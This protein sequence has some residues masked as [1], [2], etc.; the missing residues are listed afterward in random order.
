MTKATG[1][2]KTRMKATNTGENGVWLMKMLCARNTSVDTIQARRKE[3]QVALVFGSRFSELEMTATMIAARAG[4]QVAIT[5]SGNRKSAP[6]LNKTSA[7]GI[8][9]PHEMA[10]VTEKKATI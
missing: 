10:K 2:T 4:P 7:N 5:N 8:H 6:R 3:T 1:T 9:S